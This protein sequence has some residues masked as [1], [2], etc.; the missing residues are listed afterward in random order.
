MGA[1][2]AIPES[3]HIFWLTVTIVKLLIG[4]CQKYGTPSRIRSGKGG[5][6]VLVALLKERIWKDVF[7]QVI[8]KY[9]NIFITW[10][11]VGFW[12]L[13]AIFM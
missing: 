3:L 11:I 12:L 9:Y 6:N 10:R 2:T 13:K 8:K 7:N 4:A 1:S 5:E